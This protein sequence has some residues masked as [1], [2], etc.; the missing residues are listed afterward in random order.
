MEQVISFNSAAINSALPDLTVF[1]DVPPDECLRRI[2]MERKNIDLFE[3]EHI[4]NAARANYLRAFETVPQARVLVVEGDRDTGDISREIWET[5]S[6][7][8]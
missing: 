1:I 4:L 7:L 3:K 5:A 6:K 8:F 2:H